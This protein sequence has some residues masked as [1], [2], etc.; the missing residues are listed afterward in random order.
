MMMHNVSIISSS[1]IHISYV[2]FAPVS[3]SGVRIV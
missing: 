2:F 1:L 3:F